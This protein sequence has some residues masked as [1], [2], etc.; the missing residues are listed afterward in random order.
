MDLTI[1]STQTGYFITILCLIIVIF[2]PH[3][4]AYLPNIGVTNTRI[5]TR[6]G[7]IGYYS[8][9]IGASQINSQ[10]THTANKKHLTS[11][12]GGSDSSNLPD[13][14]SGYKILQNVSQNTEGSQ[15]SLLEKFKTLNPSSQ[16]KL[17]SQ[18][19]SLDSSYPGGLLS[20]VSK[21]RSLLSQSLSGANPFLEYTPSVPSGL[22]LQYATSQFTSL[23]T[24]ALK[25]T[26]LSALILVAGGLG[27]R[28]GYSGIKISLSP[29]SLALNY[30]GS[31][32]TYLELYV[33]YVRALKQRT[34]N[35]MK[36][37]IMTSGD[38][39]EK[40]RELVE[41]V[42]DVEIEIVMQE[43]VPAIEN[44]EG[45]LALEGDEILTKPHG[46]G[47]V[48][49]L[50]L[51]SN[52]LSK[53]SSSVKKLIFVQD[54]NALVSNA[55]LPAVGSNLLSSSEMTSICIPRL[56]S[57]AA[58]AITQL[59]HKT[60]PSKSLVIN[61][62]YNQLSALLDP[63]G[64]DVS[65][66]DSQYSPYPGNANNLIF[67]FKKYVETISG[68][69]QGVVNEFVN[70]KLN[71]DKTFKKPTRLECMMQDFPYLI[72]EKG[73]GSEGTGHDFVNLERW[74]TFSPAKNDLEA[75]R[76]TAEGGGRE[77][78]TLAK[79][80]SDG[81]V[82]NGVKL[83][84]GGNEVEE[85][86]WKIVGGLYVWEGPRVYLSPTFCLTKEDVKEKC[87]GMKIS[88]KSAL[89]V[90]GFNVHVDGLELDGA[91]IV[92]VKD[93]ASLKIKNFKVKNEGWKI[94]AYDEG[95]EVD[96]RDAIR[97]YEFVREGEER[98]LIEEGDWIADENGLRRV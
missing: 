73:G 38:T 98:I 8:K 59:T 36:F 61:V 32:K 12:R 27:E 17:S 26:S 10:N 21:S 22:N 28:L 40:T 35:V 54:T 47:D 23:E 80:E 67:D 37:V 31:Q 62:E 55:L 60:T 90:E 71:P 65:S 20:Y 82:A 46:H 56:P 84:V 68:P 6:I 16:S 83:R 30:D 51:S 14:Y 34:G 29:Y 24:S 78:G 81:Y 7:R 85:G 92:N 66:P 95:E 77:T 49:T 44:V 45:R 11:L 2:M 52:L 58:G 48:H 42:E 75:G 18:I 57:E 86:E 9:G 69:S 94:R 3:T 41:G 79:A 64:G 93:G 72:R 39:D 89:S 87:K 88:A 70:P 96:E 1:L 19:T 25:C 13:S 63:L 15:D 33:D 74:L 4:N 76:K 5:G 43:K 53:W 97:G 50:L 91:L